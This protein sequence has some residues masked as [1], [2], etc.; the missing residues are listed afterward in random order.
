MGLPRHAWDDLRTFV[1]LGNE[2]NALG[3]SHKRTFDAKTPRPGW[4]QDIARLVPSVVVI[5]LSF[6]LRTGVN[7]DCLTAGYLKVKRFWGAFFVLERSEIEH[8]LRSFLCFI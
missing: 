3:V 4:L 1:R 2:G 8:M 5:G 6:P 7:D